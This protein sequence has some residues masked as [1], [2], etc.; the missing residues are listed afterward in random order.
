MKAEVEEKDNGKNSQSNRCLPHTE[1]TT[2]NK[3]KIFYLLIQ[4]TPLS[5]DVL[6]TIII[7]WPAGWR[8]CLI[9]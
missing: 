8:H 6:F 2:N 1:S 4:M 3:L 5:S 7:I 9:I